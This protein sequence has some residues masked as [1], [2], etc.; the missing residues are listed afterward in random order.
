MLNCRLT[1]HQVLS[2]FSKSNFIGMNRKLLK[3]QNRVSAFLS[4]AFFLL[5]FSSTSWAQQISGKVL[6]EEN[7]ALPGVNV[8]VDGTAVG[9]T[10]NASGEYTLNVTVANSVLVFTFIGYK[11]QRIPVGNQTIINVTLAA[12]IQTL[13]EVVVVG[14]GT[15]KKVN[16]RRQLV[17]LLLRRSFPDKHPI[18][19]L[20]CRD[21]LLVF[22][23]SKILACRALKVIK[24]EF[25]ARVHSV[26]LVTRRCYQ[27][28]RLC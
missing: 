24:S 6:A 16:L 25:E 14:Y 5:L 17:Q 3:F 28:I 19:F 23:L 12:D 10:T 20:Y 8:I 9:T 11:T 21:G 4:M 26:K 1:V 22:K 27:P 18:Q 2:I 7:E 13:S 15:Q